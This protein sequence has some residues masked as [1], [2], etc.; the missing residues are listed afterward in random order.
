VTFVHPKG[1]AS[2]LRARLRPIRAFSFSTRRRRRS[3]MKASG[4][5]SVMCFSPLYGDRH[6]TNC[7]AISMLPSCHRSE[8]EAVKWWRTQS[9]RA[10]QK[11]VGGS[12]KAADKDTG[13]PQDDRPSAVSAEMV[14][15]FLPQPRP[16][17]ANVAPQRRELGSVPR[18]PLRPCSHDRANRDEQ[19]QVAADRP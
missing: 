3:T 15:V 5:F 9:G 6:T 17:L 7:N 16:M 2:P 8:P 13:R 19:F 14:G 1:S 10:E 4:S 11:A 18:L 12:E